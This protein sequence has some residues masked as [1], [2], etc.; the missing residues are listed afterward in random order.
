MQVFETTA[1]FR[2]PRGLYVLTFGELCERLSFYGL[3]NILVL[4][5]TSHFFLSDSRTY[6]LYGTY[7][8]LSYALPILGGILADH[9]L[10]FR[11]A[12]TMG[13]I[14][15]VIGNLLLAVSNFTVFS[16]GLALIVCGIGLYKANTT[17]LVGKLYT[18]SD[19]R[20]ES[21]FVIF[22]TGMNIG[23]T[24]GAIVYG[25][26]SRLWG[27]RYSFVFSVLIMAIVLS[28]F[29]RYFYDN[30]FKNLLSLSPTKT[31]KKKKLFLTILF[32][33]FC[34]LL[35]LLFFNPRF[36]DDFLAIAALIAI[37]SFII[38]AL[39]QA[40]QKRNHVF[41]LLILSFFGMCFFAASFQVG[42]SINLF[43]HRDVNRELL[44]WVIP[45]IMFT[46]LYPLAVILM[47][48]I[49]TLLW[50]YL[51]AHQKEPQTPVKL[52]YGLLLGS[53]AFV[54]FM[55]ATL[56]NQHN[57][58]S[59]IPLIWIIVGN[60]LLGTGELVLTPAILASISRLAPQNL[61]GTM[62]GAWFLFVAFGGFLSSN[63]AK[64]SSHINLAT[65][66]KFQSAVIYEHTFTVIAIITAAIAT[67]LLLL[68]PGINKLSQ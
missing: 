2:Q 43:I 53:L 58:M 55:L 16:I 24:I 22:Y 38:I 18:N 41:A 11:L 7:V 63:L 35:S 37:I 57:S 20:R 34:P 25:F 1:E 14:L 42:S 52:F 6:S 23:A 61:Q 68:I 21:G 59:S 30:K 45:T 8:S 12:I 3:Q 60:L 62:M 27:A 33:I 50:G 51:A 66:S 46:S 65:I 17:A 26:P 32:I 36:S 54:A 31:T 47:A 28:I 10:D 44:H 15:L 64:I 56:N 13:A 5:V 19:Q 39:T 4:Y 29:L 67:L 9:F 40:P 48:P 49:I